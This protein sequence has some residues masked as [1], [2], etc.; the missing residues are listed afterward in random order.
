[1]EHSRSAQAMR[2]PASQ[3]CR[4]RGPGPGS[5]T[6]ARVSS[7]VVCASA[8]APNGRT[9]PSAYLADL[10]AASNKISLRVC[11]L[12]ECGRTCQHTWDWIVLD[13]SPPFSQD[14]REAQV[15]WHSSIHIGYQH[16]PPMRELKSY[17]A[18]YMLWRAKFARKSSMDKL[19]C[20]L[21]NRCEKS[22]VIQQL[23]RLQRARSRDNG[24]GATMALLTSEA[25]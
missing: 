21:S 23:V 1:M 13:L 2:R 18:L 8:S 3:V 6:A 4:S 17:G 5:G 7:G 12:P 25:L 10:P 16:S 22:L 9:P 19:V 14:G 15:Q 11:V 24:A 20:R